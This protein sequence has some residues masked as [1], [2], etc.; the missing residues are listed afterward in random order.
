MRRRQFVSLSAIATAAWSPAAL[1]QQSAMPVI[2]FLSSRSPGESASNVD[3][4]H[5]GL[6]ETGYVDGENASIEYRWAEGQYDRLPALAAEL[7]R[8]QVAAIVATGGNAPALAAKAAT[9]KI[10][11]VLISGSDPVRAGLVASLN[12]PGGNVTGVTFIATALLAKR[13]ELLH[14]LVP[15]ATRASVLVNPSYPDSDLQQQELR[16]AAEAMK[17]QVHVVTAST[18]GD[19]DAAFATFV[20]QQPDAL[21][22]ANDPFFDSRRAQIVAL[23]ER[24]TLPAIYPDRAYVAEGGLVSYGS[25][26]GDSYR[27]AGIYT[28]RILKGAKAADLPVEQPTTIELIINRKT[29]RA[30]GLAIPP[31][32]LA[33]A[34]E[35]TE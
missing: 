1:A 20:Q 34:D 21:L 27:R 23:A 2:G 17:Q 7:V 29:A 19:I 35:V 15:K 33:R 25:S 4:F 22:V 11:I 16:E 5:Q 24:H 30:L 28:G 8:R 31:S 10:P 6:K 3:A 18:V 14:Q 9:K 32:I 12:R 26:L 13:L